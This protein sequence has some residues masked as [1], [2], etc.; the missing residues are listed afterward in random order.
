MYVFSNIIT[1]ASS[2]N[3]HYFTLLDSENPI[4]ISGN[5]MLNG[6]LNA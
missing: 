4:S 1:I 6:M 2:Q 5:N 3:I